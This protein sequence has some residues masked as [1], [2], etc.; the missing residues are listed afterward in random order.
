MPEKIRTFM[1]KFRTFLSNRVQKKRL[2][3]DNLQA[4]SP[5]LISPGSAGLCDAGLSKGVGYRLE[6]KSSVAGNSGF[7]SQGGTAFRSGV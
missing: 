7:S 2:G 1:Y 4:R 6:R 5:L 3:E